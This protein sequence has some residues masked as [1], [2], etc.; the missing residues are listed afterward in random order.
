MLDSVKILRKLR[1]VA[2]RN[3]IGTI[4]NVSTDQ[5]LTALTFDDGPSP[6]F[7]PALLDILR[8]YNARATF[9]VVGKLAHRYHGLV[10]MTALAGHAIGNHSWD[11][12]S[13]PL[14]SRQQRYQQLLMCQEAIAPYD[15]GLFR[16]PYGHQ[17]FTSRLDALI[18]GYKVVAW[19]VAAEDWLDHNSNWLFDKV[20]ARITAGTIILFHDGLYTFAKERFVDRNA[21]LEAVEMLL[22]QFSSKFDFVTIPELLERGRPRLQNW[23]Q[24]EKQDWFN[25]LKV[26]TV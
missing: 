6:Q 20:A 2:M 3:L 15:C 11:H 13:L 1:S 25:N 7:T 22:A 24:Q 14:L 10:E 4:T 5:P 12:S 19:N 16:P 17:S 23:Y 9:F 21:T 8:K 26:A 18:L